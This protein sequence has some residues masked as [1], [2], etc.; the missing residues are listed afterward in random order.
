MPRCELFLALLS[1]GT[2]AC[3]SEQG[4]AGSGGSGGSSGATASL[5]VEP[6]VWTGEGTGSV[7]IQDG[8]SIEL[9]SA[10]QGGHVSRIGARVTGLDTDKAELVARLRDPKDDAVVAESS[11]TTTMLPV[12]SL[13]GVKQ[14]DPGDLYAVV[15]LPLCPDYAGRPIA[16]TEYLLEVHVTELY[17]DF[18]EGSVSLHV[19]PTCEQPP[20]PELEHCSCECGPDYGPAKCAGDGG[21]LT[22]AG[23][24]DAG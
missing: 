20:G 22:E 9:W 8:G 12:P 23:T 14:P 11:R 1:L 19:T 17:G 3:S 10:P 18:T 13:P 4:P 16:D 24:P 6:Y 15:H 7:F 21:D 2:L 5:G